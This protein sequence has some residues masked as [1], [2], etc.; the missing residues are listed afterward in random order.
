MVAAAGVA[1]IRRMLKNMESEQET[2][3]CV[4]LK[5]GC[6]KNSKPASTYGHPVVGVPDVVVPC[7]VREEEEHDVAPD[8]V[9]RREEGD[10]RERVQE[11]IGDDDVEALAQEGDVDS[12]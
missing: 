3:P 1:V 9:D 4:R 12:K 11:G 8:S 2:I 5:L 7:V 6:I 10:Q